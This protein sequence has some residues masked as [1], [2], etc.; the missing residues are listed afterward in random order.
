M[1]GS[2]LGRPVP[3][4]LDPRQSIVPAVIVFALGLG[5]FVLDATSNVRPGPVAYLLTPTPVALALY[6]RRRPTTGRRRLLGLAVWGL[7]STT[8]AGLLTILVAIGTRLPRP[9]E[10]W[11]FLLLDAGVFLWFILSLAGAFVLAARWDGRRSTVALAAGPAVQFVGFLLFV[12]VTAES[13]VLATLA[14]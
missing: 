13:V 5:V 7:V 6:V 1:S 8:A 4:L 14:A 2:A 9:Y 10:A 12:V 11:E 3:A